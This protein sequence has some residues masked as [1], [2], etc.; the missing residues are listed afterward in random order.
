PLI[1]ISCSVTNAQLNVKNHLDENGNLVKHKDFQ[2]RWRNKENNLFRWDYINERGKR[3]AKLFSPLYTGYQVNYPFFVQQL[4]KLTNKNFP[5]NLTIILSYTYLNDLCSNESS[6]N[7]NRQKIL[8]WK[9]FT[10]QQK[11][12]IEETQDR[13]FLEFF[14]AGIALENAENKLDEYFFIDKGNFLR[15]NLFQQPSLCGSYAIIK[16]DGEVLVRN[17]EYDLLYM[18]QHLNPVNWKIFFPDSKI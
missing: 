6:N 1:F 15:N 5:K 13:I 8:S 10:N 12:I 7:W 16:P 3:E 14:E 9:E 17:G 4:E 2:K 18:V 11:N